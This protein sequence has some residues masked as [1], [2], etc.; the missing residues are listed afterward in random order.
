MATWLLLVIVG[1]GKKSSLLKLLRHDRNGFC[2]HLG[3]SLS[4]SGVVVRYGNF[5]QETVLKMS[6]Q[7]LPDAQFVLCHSC[8]SSQLLTGDSPRVYG[9][10][11]FTAVWSSYHS[12]AESTKVSSRPSGELTF[13]WCAGSSGSLPFCINFRILLPP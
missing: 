4:F 3:P 8:L 11:F 10:P 13:Q 9:L 1:G 5:S 12:P 2:W 6:E 7:H